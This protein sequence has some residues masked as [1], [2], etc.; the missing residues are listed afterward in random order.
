MGKHNAMARYLGVKVD[1]RQ[2][3]DIGVAAAAIVES[4]GTSMSITE[5]V[6]ET[7]TVPEVRGATDPVILK[8]VRYAADQG[9]LRR[10]E[11]NRYST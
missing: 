6:K 2:L 5:I 10:L 1:H 4:R 8:A 3:E 11:G 9:L 7:R